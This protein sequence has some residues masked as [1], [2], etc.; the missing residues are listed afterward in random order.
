MRLEFSNSEDTMSISTR[1]SEVFD[2]KNS[3]RAVFITPA[4]YY[5]FIKMTQKK[6]LF[7]SWCDI[8]T[9]A[10]LSQDENDF[11]YYEPEHNLLNTVA[12]SRK[13]ESVVEQ[14]VRAF[15]SINSY[16]SRPVELNS[17]IFYF[18]LKIDKLHQSGEEVQCK[19]LSPQK[20][21]CSVK[22]RKHNFHETQKA[23]TKIMNFIRDEVEKLDNDGTFLL[24]NTS[25]ERDTLVLIEILMLGDMFKSF[26][27]SCDS[28]INMDKMF[29]RSCKTVD[30]FSDEAAADY[31]SSAGISW[32][33]DNILESYGDLIDDLV[34]E[35]ATLLDDRVPF[36]SEHFNNLL[37]T[38]VEEDEKSLYHLN[39][40]K[41]VVKEKQS[42]NK[43]RLAS[44]KL[45]VSP[46]L[47]HMTHRQWS[48]S[49]L[50]PGLEI[51]NKI[52]TITDEKL[53]MLS[54]KNTSTSR[55]VLTGGSILA[56]ASIIPDTDSSSSEPDD[57]IEDAADADSDH[58]TIDK[59]LETTDEE[60]EENDDEVTNISVRTRRNLT[61]TES[62]ASPVNK[63]KVRFEDCKEMIS[64]LEL[65]L[66]NLDQ[67]VVE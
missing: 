10:R 11:K 64:S 26:R 62:S 39:T 46:G 61:R 36:Y 25:E 3:L 23:A 27:D 41:L 28:F 31:C 2:G 32:C 35:E 1:I 24:I 52:L 5:N 13:Q 22:V 66:M 15:K 30:V 60:E 65:F 19:L 53:V 51:Q 49:S 18:I 50:H 48:P 20:N 63:V 4:D 43:D 57:S 47:G 67:T 9:S 45:A 8:V 34:A 14:M 55:L 42:I 54:V 59:Y 21:V 37:K 56:T 29:E 40:V 38:E 58:S 33:S 7:S 16:E 44:I 12:E 6:Q 17:C